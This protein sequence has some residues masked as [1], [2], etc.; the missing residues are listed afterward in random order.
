[1]LQGGVV[2]YN[3]TTQEYEWA[4]PYIY[5]DGWK[6]AYPYAYNSGWK[7]IGGAGVPMDYFI[8]SDGEYEQVGGDYYLVR[9]SY[10]Q[11]LKDSGSNQL[12]GSDGVK[13]SVTK[14]L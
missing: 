8:N 9:R 14:E 4:V 12:L 10:E 11:L 2:I 5:S 6:R 1:M 13:L 7:A 3:S